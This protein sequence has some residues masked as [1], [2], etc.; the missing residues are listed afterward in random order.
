MSS[1]GRLALSGALSGI[2][3]LW[4]VETGQLIRRLYGHSSSVLGAAF[5]PH[6]RI[7]V[8]SSQSGS[9]IVW[10]LERG[11]ALRRY[12]GHRGAVVDL[13]IAPDGRTVFSAGADLTIRQWRIDA[14][15]KALMDWI[16]ENRHVPELTPDQRVRYRLDLLDV[17]ASG[18]TRDEG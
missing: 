8:T 9:L 6:G 14:T 1:D 18:E 3:F 16:R 12:L 13:C 2:V 4:N 17:G 7:A 15:Q 10:D 5:G 11:E